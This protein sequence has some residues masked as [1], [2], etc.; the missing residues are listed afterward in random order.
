META[1]VVAMQKAQLQEL[2][3]KHKGQRDCLAKLA[4]ELPGGFTKG[5]ICSQLRRLGL[6]LKQQAAKD[7]VRRA[8][9]HEML[10]LFALEVE[11][12]G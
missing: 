11:C 1:R 5:Q 4:T 8:G 10:L 9:S 2:F 3:E 7:M 6:K 12:S